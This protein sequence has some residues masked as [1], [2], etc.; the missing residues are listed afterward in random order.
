MPR[1]KANMTPQWDRVLRF[2][3]AYV[4][5]NGVSPSYRVLAHGL[6]MKS[7]ANVYRIVKR[8]EQ[9]GHLE[10]KPRKYNGVKVKDKSVAEVLSL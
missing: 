8:L 4:K 6:G 2:I 1:V 5:L 10:V 3:K 9:E 7:R